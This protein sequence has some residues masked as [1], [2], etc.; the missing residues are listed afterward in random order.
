[1]KKIKLLFIVILFT[2]S[3]GLVKAQLTWD[4]QV[5][6]TPII[7]WVNLTDYNTRGYS[8]NDDVWEFYEN[9]MTDGNLIFG[10]DFAFY[11]F[12]PMDYFS[13][14]SNGVILIDSW[15]GAYQG[16]IIPNTNMGY[17][18]QYGGNSNGQITSSD[19]IKY[20]VWQTP[21][22]FTV[23]T[24]EL[25]YQIGLNAT[26]YMAD[27]QIH[28]V[29]NLN[30]IEIAYSNV[31]GSTGTSEYCGLNFGDGTHFTLLDGIT[32]SF[33]TTDA[34]YVFYPGF[35]DELELTSIS[36]S[37][38]PFS[39]DL[40]P[41][42]ITANILN[43]GSNS[44]T[45]FN[46]N[47]YV[48]SELTETYL[49]TESLDQFEL[50]HHEFSTVIAPQQDGEIINIVVEIDVSD[51]DVSNN[52][53]AMKL[54][55]YSTSVVE[56]A[57]VCFGS[58]A[59]IEAT[60]GDSFIWINPEYPN[61]PL[62]VGEGAFTTS[63][64][65]YEPT[66]FWVKAL[67]DDIYIS[68][69]ENDFTYVNHNN[70]TGDDRGG[71]AITPEYFYVVGDENTVRMS[72]VSLTGQV[73]LPIR[74]GLFSN[75][76]DGKLYS[77]YNTD[78]SE[79]IDYDD[80]LF[81]FTVNAI[82]ELDEDLEFTTNIISLDI[83]FDVDYNNYEGGVFAGKGM[84]MVKTGDDNTLYQ[85]DIATGTTTTVGVFDELVD[86]MN[87]ENW[88]SWGF[89]ESIDNIPVSLIFAKNSS[90]LARL[91]LA[92]G[93]SEIVFTFVDDNSGYSPDDLHSFTYSPWS[94]RIYFHSETDDEDGGYFN[95][96]NG[97]S[98]NCWTSV[99]VDIVHPSSAGFNSNTQACNDNSSM[100]LF[101]YVVGNP[102]LGGEWAD[103]DATGALNAGIFDASVVGA[104]TYHFTYTVVSELPCESESM[105]TLT[106]NVA[107]VP[108][109]GLAINGS[110]CQNTSPIFNLNDA[111]DGTQDIYGYW[112]DD[113]NTGVLSG[114][115][116]NST[117]LAL[118]DYNFSYHA[119][120]SGAC[121][122][123]VETITITVELCNGI[124]NI[125]ASD[126]SIWPNPSTGNI[127]LNIN[128]SGATEIFVE[129]TNIQGQIIFSQI[130][131]DRN[132]NL[133]DLPKG[134]YTVK[135]VDNDNIYIQKLILE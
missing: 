41:N 113:D 2:I 47:L 128:D 107:E 15:N 116:I 77:L 106:V 102:D 115:Q 19:G 69:I 33:P 80:S 100:N 66:E 114:S 121:N 57:T 97:T 89:I 36:T 130:V 17:I 21:E 34:T 13:I 86:N 124:E 120:G 28:F 81:P 93:T 29:E 12:N 76:N 119:I 133:N 59:T 6:S 75:L 125:N 132:L 84:V 26:D 49:V 118:G 27:I 35:N 5:S 58:P 98:G 112:T 7:G 70:V 78:L 40:Q 71:V 30:I 99:I 18:F 39:C 3:S 51:F 55:D 60:G 131:S 24:L 111:L 73:S 25:Q 83:P 65:V 16:E 63:Q 91:D 74:D 127:Q 101:D 88:A 8:A 22:G 85:I 96:S 94:N 108:L 56:N 103:V 67:S 48:N 32:G 135:V 50:L 46:L 20:K 4:Y 43:R 10:D 126:L 42:T 123:D 11:D 45:G 110:V 72:V 9:N 82:I 117:T 54:I 53:N 61:S 105:I 62:Y 92:T 87:T 1:M 68:M 38:E 37:D 90:N 109:A 104:G 122:D 23:F 129:I 95:V 52:T 64:N 79:D 44:Q 134:F 31:T 14:T